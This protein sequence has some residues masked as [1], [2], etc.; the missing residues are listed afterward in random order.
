VIQTRQEWRVKEKADTPAPMTSNDDMDLLDD[1]E[2]PL[3]KEGSPPPI[4]M[5]ANMVFMLPDEFR[6]VKEEVAQMYLGP[7]EAVFE[8]TEELSQHLKPLYVRRREASLHDAHRRRRCH[9][10]DVVL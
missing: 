7:K 9:Q 5:D 3:I 4:S 2:P 8:K 6:G 1:D 10:S